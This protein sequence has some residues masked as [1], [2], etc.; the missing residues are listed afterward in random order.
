MKSLRTEGRRPGGG[1]IEAAEGPVTERA[2]C[3]ADHLDALQLASG[4]VAAAAWPGLGP[5]RPRVC[6]GVSQAGA[7]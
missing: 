6:P 1:R 3:S 5:P 4:R 7:S 2:R